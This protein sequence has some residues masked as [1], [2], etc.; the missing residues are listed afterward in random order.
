MHRFTGFWWSSDSKAIAFEEV[1]ES[2]IPEYRIMHQGR[3]EVSWEDHRYPFAGAANPKVRLGVV[4][5]DAGATT[6]EEPH[7]VWMDLGDG[8]VRA[9]V[10][11]PLVPSQRVY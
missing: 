6:A 1:D 3:E 4:R 5:L 2:H 9:L 11:S 8:A 10:V 7:V